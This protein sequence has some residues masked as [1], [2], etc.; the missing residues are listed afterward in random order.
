MLK[1]AFGK[2]KIYVKVTSINTGEINENNNFLY[3][4]LTKKL[5]YSYTF[6]DKNVYHF[7]NLAKTWNLLLLKYYLERLFHYLFNL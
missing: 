6:N 7:L 1:H 2:V 5:A 4:I 3:V